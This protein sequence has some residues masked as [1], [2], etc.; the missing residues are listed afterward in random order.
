MGTKIDI[1]TVE[2]M[3][4]V[5]HD[6]VDHTFN[7]LKIIEGKPIDEVNFQQE[8]HTRRTEGGDF[9]VEGKT[10]TLRVK[11]QNP[12][13]KPAPDAEM[14]V[15]TH[16][17][18]FRLIE[19]SEARINHLVQVLIGLKAIKDEAAAL[20][21]I[22]A[23]GVFYSPVNISGLAQISALMF[24]R[25]ELLKEAPEPEQAPEVEPVSDGEPK[26]T[27][28]PKPTEPALVGAAATDVTDAEN[29]KFAEDLKKTEE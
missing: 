9:L 3:R 27:D 22:N 10:I 2:G 23:G 28:E 11:Y 15:R 25:V 8:L 12:I 5:V 29:E 18:A 21:T 7:A 26:T 1:E 16:E 14:L 17:G 4:K 13:L 20:D 19:P 24:E 6:T